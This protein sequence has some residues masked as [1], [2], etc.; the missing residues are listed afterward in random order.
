MNLSDA[1]DSEFYF[2]SIQIVFIIESNYQKRWY[3]TTAENAAYF[4]FVEIQSYKNIFELL[5]YNG[6][7]RL[8][9]LVLAH[10][11]GAEYNKYWKTVLATYKA[12]T[13]F[14]VSTKITV[15]D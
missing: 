10:F 8:L 13:R 4:N 6:I 9:P 2:G 5:T 1:K 15:I 11:K 14:N 3:C 12:L 7:V